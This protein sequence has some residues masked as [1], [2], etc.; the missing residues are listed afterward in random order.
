MDNICSF[1]F[2][3]HVYNSLPKTEED[4]YDS[5]LDDSND[6]SSISIGRT[7]SLPDS[8]PHQIYINSGNGE[9]TNIEV[10][11]WYNGRWHTIGKYYLKFCPECGRKLDEYEI[12]EKGISFKRRS[13]E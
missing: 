9:A 12:E 8:K 10:C 2:N 6:F 13:H 7:C 11:E 4:Y 5:G 3:A 1:C